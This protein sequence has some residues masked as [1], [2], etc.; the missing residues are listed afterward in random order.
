MVKNNIWKEDKLEQV[1]YINNTSNTIIWSDELYNIL[2]IQDSIE[3]TDTINRLLTDK[4]ILNFT[5]SI[6]LNIDGDYDPEMSVLMLIDKYINDI[7][8]ILL[9]N[10][11]D[12]GTVICYNC[13]DRI[14][15]YLFKKL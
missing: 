13:P 15:F 5:Q 14:F 1:A 4:S 6:V 3:D 11:Y 7:E 9:S 12:I 8:S 10:I 2:Y